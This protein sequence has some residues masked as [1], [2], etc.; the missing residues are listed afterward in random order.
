MTAYRQPGPVPSRTGI[1]PHRA[2]AL[3]ETFRR[4]IGADLLAEKRRHYRA[5]LMTKQGTATALLRE[6][7]PL[8][9]SFDSYDKV[10]F[11]QRRVPKSLPDELTDLANVAAQ[12]L[13]VGPTLEEE[14]ARHHKHSPLGPGFRSTLLEWKTATTLV[15]VNDARLNWLPPSQVGPEFAA[16]AEGH[17][18]EVECKYVTHMVTELFG[19]AEA[20]DLADIP[21]LPHCP[22]KACLVHRV[23]PCACLGA[24]QVRFEAP[25]A[26]CA[27]N[28]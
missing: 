10:T 16:Q 1:Y 18:L 21:V 27:R 2:Y 13:V 8:L 17:E 26:R 24:L 15:R 23:E 11:G 12:F 7:H 14:D 19:D 5:K 28:H 20:A 3:I 6:K 4:W 9:D 22:R 25:E